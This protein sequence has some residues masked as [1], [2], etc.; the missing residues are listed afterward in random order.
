VGICLQAVILLTYLGA[1]NSY[2]PYR[3]VTDRDSTS[4]LDIFKRVVDSGRHL[5]MM[6]HFS[7]PVEL[8]SPIVQEAIRRIRMTGANIRCQA[9]LVKHVNDS[10]DVW[11]KVINVC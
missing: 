11:E 1:P 6:A 7:H 4:L 5:S 10:A 2:W 8:E 9:P 3:Y